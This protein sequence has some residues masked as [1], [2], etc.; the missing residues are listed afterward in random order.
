MFLSSCL[1]SSASTTS[2]AVAAATG[3]HQPPG[4]VGH[5]LPHRRASLILNHHTTLPTP[6]PL[7]TSCLF[8]LSQKCAK[9]GNFPPWLPGLASGLAP[10]MEGGPGK[11]APWA[12][13]SE[14]FLAWRRPGCWDVVPKYEPA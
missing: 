8:P 5:E 7:P 14:M 12:G 1:C 11:A 9:P 2:A 10:R 13:A 4:Q 6:S 3:G